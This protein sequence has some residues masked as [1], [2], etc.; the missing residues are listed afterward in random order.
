MSEAVPA[1]TSTRP[2]ASLSP[3]VVTSLSLS[4]AINHVDF[5][6]GDRAELRQMSSFAAAARA[7]AMAHV[8][9][10]KHEN[11]FGKTGVFRHSR[12]FVAVRRAERTTTACVRA[13]CPSRCNSSPKKILKK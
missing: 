4:G 7:Q 6:A 3:H 11:S 10:S 9:P 2:T 13:P 5:P 12:K 1:S 8:R